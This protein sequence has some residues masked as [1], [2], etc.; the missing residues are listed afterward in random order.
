MAR[1]QPHTLCKTSFLDPYQPSSRGIV[2]DLQE[3][4]W[5]IWTFERY[6]LDKTIMK[7]MRGEL[8]L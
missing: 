8:L 3:S 4:N 6:L 7:Q 5:E 1:V 2:W